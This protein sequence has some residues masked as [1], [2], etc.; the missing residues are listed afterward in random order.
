MKEV[1]DAQIQVIGAGFGR[2]GTAS[3]KKALEILGFNPCY[4]MI[5]AIKQ[6]HGVQWKKFADNPKD[7]H[8]L[9]SLLGESGYLASCDFPSSPYW[10]EQLKLYPDAKVI[11]TTRD[12]EKW[13]QSC[14]DTIFKMMPFHPL[15]PFGAILYNF[16]GFSSPGFMDMVNK[17][18]R[19]DSF[20]GDWNKESVI[21][22]YH[23]HNNNVIK[24][25]PADKL[26][27]FEVSEG[28]EPLCKFLNVPVPAADV[29]FPHVNDSQDFN[30]GMRRIC[31]TGYTRLMLTISVVILVGSGVLPYIKHSTS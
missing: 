20:H 15:R 10:A 18:I 16:F 6:Q 19:E 22:C 21:K 7:L 9:H 2:T 5:E 11:L 12:A 23:D 14:C 3:F 28:W 24:T 25:C 31:S 27:V 30:N 8:I 26:L 4:H 29:P 13:Y 1:K 17:T